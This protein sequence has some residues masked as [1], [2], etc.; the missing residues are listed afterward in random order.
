VAIQGLHQLVE[1]KNARI[2]ALER[3]LTKVE[4]LHSEL[5]ALKLA[6]E[7]MLQAK[8]VLARRD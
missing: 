6:L 8:A 3:R 4:S 1:D 5:A 2:A 7:E